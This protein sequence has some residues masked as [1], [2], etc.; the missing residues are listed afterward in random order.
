MNMDASYPGNKTALRFPAL[1]YVYA[2]GMC[3]I[4]RRKVLKKM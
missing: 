4:H 1:L 2:S 3:E